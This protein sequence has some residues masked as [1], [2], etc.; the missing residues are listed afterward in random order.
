MSKDDRRSYI[1]AVLCLMEKPPRMTGL[2]GVK[3][4]YDDF[5]VAHMNQ[6]LYI[7]VTGNFF[8][9]HRYYVWSYEQVSGINIRPQDYVLSILG[10]KK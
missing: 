8:S 5:V 3:S 2:P 7:H 4:R 6:T 1:K 9:W 10:I